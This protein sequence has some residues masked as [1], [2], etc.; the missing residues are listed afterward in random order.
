MLP[1]PQRVDGCAGQNAIRLMWSDV[2]ERNSFIAGYQV[3]RKAAYINPRDGKEM[4]VLEML[5]A[6]AETF[7]DTSAKKGVMY[8]D[9]LTVK[10]KSGAE[11]APSGW[12]SAKKE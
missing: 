4:K 8:Y 3:F 9:F 7:E 6:D 11:S 10:Y 2:S 5:K 1:I 12:A